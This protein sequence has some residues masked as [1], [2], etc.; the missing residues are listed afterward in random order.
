MKI[1]LAYIAVSQGR[2]TVDYAARFVGSYIACP[3]GIEH[4]TVIVC[5]GGPL[6]RDVALLFDLIPCSFLPRVN[7][8][9]W[10]IS[11]YQDVAKQFSC[12]MLVCFG[13]SVYFHRA[14]WLKKLADAWTKHGPG[15]YGLFSSFLVRA[16][17]NTTAFVCFPD[18]LRRYPRATSHA[19]RYRFEH[20]EHAFWKFVKSTKSPVKLV[21]WDGVYDPF[22]WRL[23]Q[24]ILWRGTQSNCLAY[25]SHTD[26][27]FGADA[28][29]RLRWEQWINQPFK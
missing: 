6:S 7:D 13:E 18:H 12:E 23:P 25:C 9:G 26:H 27:Y 1:L 2:I 19:D 28:Q 22:Q 24:N 15:M 3:P 20:G 14:G 29:T 17:L 16:H 5:N 10:D 11:G 21:T 4:E 8:P